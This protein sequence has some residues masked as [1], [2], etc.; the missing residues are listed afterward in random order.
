MKC[1]YPYVV[2]N[3]CDFYFCETQFKKKNHKNSQTVF[4]H[5][6]KVSGVQSMITD[7]INQLDILKLSEL[8]FKHREHFDIAFDIK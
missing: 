7:L 1:T 8:M 3:L 4:V 6:M 5:K 2:P